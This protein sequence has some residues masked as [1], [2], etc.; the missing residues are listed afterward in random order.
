MDIGGS[1]GTIEVG[2]TTDTAEWIQLDEIQQTAPRAP[3][4][5]T[6]IAAFNAAAQ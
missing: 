3:I 2:G 5:D 4:I 1:L 6:A